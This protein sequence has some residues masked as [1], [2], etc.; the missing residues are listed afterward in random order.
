MIRNIA[1]LFVS[2]VISFVIAL[3]VLETVYLSGRV[4]FY[5]PELAAWNPADDLSSN[6]QKETILFMGDSFTAGNMSYPNILRAQFPHWRIIN[7]GVPG[8]GIIQTHA[9]AKKRIAQFPP[10]TFVYQI[11]I[12]N[13]LFDIRYPVNWEMVSLARNIYWSISKRVRSVAYINYRLGQIRA[14]E[15]YRYAEH[16]EQSFPYQESDIFDVEKF[17]E[18]DKIYNAAEHSLI[19]DTILVQGERAKDFDLLTHKLKEVFSSLPEACK[20]VVLVVP[21]MSQMNEVYLERSIQLGARF[22]DPARILEVEYR[23]L[24]MLKERLPEATVL[25]ALI[26]LRMAEEEG[27]H[28]FFTNDPHLN[29]NGQNALAEYVAQHLGGQTL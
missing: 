8:T 14:S 6:V 28:V 18:R 24:T 10:K 2:S 25:N 27:V 13:D 1:L 5:R 7:S 17:T 12:G 3:I 16:T 20:K 26:P 29:P 22:S 19:Q 4:D 15:D 23:F 11:Y 21:H 9:M